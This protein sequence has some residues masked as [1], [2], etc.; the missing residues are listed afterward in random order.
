[1][2]LGPSGTNSKLARKKGKVKRHKK[3]RRYKQGTR[4]TKEIN[5]LQVAR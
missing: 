4:E 3:N 1:M 2:I 5:K